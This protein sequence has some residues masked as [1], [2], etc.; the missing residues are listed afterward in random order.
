MLD[1][2]SR[3]L[4]SGLALT[5]V[6]AGYGVAFDSNPPEACRGARRRDP[7]TNRCAVSGHK[8]GLEACSS[9]VCDCSDHVFAEKL[10]IECAWVVQYQ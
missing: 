2:H 6:L 10:W 7:A 1:L 4:E 9:S 8:L 5:M 3:R